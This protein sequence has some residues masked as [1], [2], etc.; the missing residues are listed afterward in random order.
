M[1]DLVQIFVVVL[2][3]GG[4]LFLQEDKAFFE[5]LLLV[6]GPF[7]SLQQWLIGLLLG[8]VYCFVHNTRDCLLGLQR[9]LG[10]MECA[11]Y[12]SRS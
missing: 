4:V 7:E 8:S 10:L 6:Y 1:L 12:L 11:R 9:G 5:G 3:S 2:C